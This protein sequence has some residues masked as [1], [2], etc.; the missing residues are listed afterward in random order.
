MQDGERSVTVRR[1]GGAQ[2]V[3]ALYHTVPGAH[4]DAIADGG[5]RRSDDRRARGAGC[6]ARSS[7]RRRR[8]P[9]SRGTS[10]SHD[11]G[12]II[13]WAQVPPSDSLAAA[14]DAL[15]A[16]VEGV[17]AKPITA[18]EVRSRARRRRCASSTRRSTIRR[19]SAWRS[20]SRSRTGDWRLFFLQRDQ[21]RKLTPPTCSAW[22]S[23]T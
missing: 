6:T 5:A 12:D 2:F 19:S 7:R 20:P 15:I 8:A 16:T 13:F 11:P 22:R 17:K 10:C 21:W 23:N 9:S 3:A 1:V 4:P 14:R 18:A